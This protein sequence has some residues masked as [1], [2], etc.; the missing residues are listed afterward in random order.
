MRKQYVEPICEIV[1]MAFNDVMLLSIEVGV[2]WG[3][4]KVWEEN[5]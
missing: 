5:K 2:D 4:W 1:R 3:N